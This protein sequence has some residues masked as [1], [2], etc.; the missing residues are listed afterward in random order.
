MNA[1]KYDLGAHRPLFEAL[2]AAAAAARKA[3]MPPGRRADVVDL[4]TLLVADPDLFDGYVE[5]LRERRQG[6]GWDVERQL[7]QAR[8]DVPWAQIRR[9][10]F[11]DLPDDVLADLATSPEALE[12]LMEVEFGGEEAPG[13]WYFDAIKRVSAW[14][15]LPASYMENAR[16]KMEEA[17]RRL[18][19]EL[20]QEKATVPATLQARSWAAFA[21]PLAMAAC[22]LL[23]AFI[24]WWSRGGR[25]PDELVA[26]SAVVEP[27]KFRGAPNEKP[28]EVRVTAPFDGFIVVI[29]LAPDR[30]HQVV[31]G[32]GDD[33]ISAVGGRPSEGVVI[34][35]DSTRVLYAVTETPAAEPIRRFLGRNARSFTA[36]DEPDL[37]RAL[38]DLLK[39]KGY[40]R[41]ALGSSPVPVPP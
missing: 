34:P 11:T 26:A 23:G 5:E 35:A 6:L 24:G 21:M 1:G 8:T 9:S 38:L 12:A 31:P 28:P 17:S 36:D 32:L 2:F 41:V 16:R 39:Q 3:V 22:L 15:P 37:R 19:A 18:D 25:A 30:K 10:G 33:D 4:L 40:R 29:A 27:A 7:L 20:A 13:P 14:R